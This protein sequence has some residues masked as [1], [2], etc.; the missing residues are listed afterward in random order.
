MP[1]L[2]S[3]A[4]H[5]YDTVG[6]R[7]VR[8]LYGVVAS[9]NASKGIIVTTSRLSRDATKEIDRHPW[10]LGKTEYQDLKTWI[11]DYLKRK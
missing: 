2:Q 11:L 9:E 1:V 10:R 4:G 6:V 7:E 8:A 5:L 3:S